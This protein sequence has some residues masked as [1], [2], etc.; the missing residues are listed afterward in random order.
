M[1]IVD[2]LRDLHP[3]V[4]V[5]GIAVVAG[6]ALVVLL[7]LVVVVAAVVG[8]FVLGVGE[9][10]GPE[11]EFTASNDGGEVVVTYRAGDRL[12]AGDVVVE[13]EPAGGG[14][15]RTTAWADLAGLSHDEQ[16]PAGSSVTVRSVE[17]GDVIRVVYRSGGE[18]GGE[19]LFEHTA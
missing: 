2:E 17:S 18:A 15:V 13:V 7:A 6:I 4:L 19:V 8:T 5:A 1:G 3:A 12:L 11:A 14:G 16:I 10:V 9:E